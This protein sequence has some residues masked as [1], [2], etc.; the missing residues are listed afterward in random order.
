MAGVEPQFEKLSKDEDPD[1]YIISINDKRRH[2]THG[3]R[4]LGVA[5]IYPAPARVKRKGSS[6]SEQ[7]KVHKGV[8]SEAREIVRYPDLAYQVRD[9]KVKFDHA[10]AEARSRAQAESNAGHYLSTL[11]IEAPDLAQMA[12]QEQL[13][14]GEAWAAF[15]QR[16]SEAEAALDARDLVA[17]Q[18][19]FA[20]DRVALW[21]QIFR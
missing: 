19:R 2:I 7:L 8:L 3:Q 16:Q 20:K 4:A 14:V 21:R 17:Y 1:K 6:P 13:T 18:G 9:G 11:R 15:E 12:V 5:L 10:L